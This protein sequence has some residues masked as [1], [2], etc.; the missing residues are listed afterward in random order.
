MKIAAYL[1][2]S[3]R[4]RSLAES[5]VAGFGRH[6]EEVV[7]YDTSKTTGPHP[8]DL[9]VFV[10]VRLTSQRV[11]K[12]ARAVGQK[13]MLLDKGYFKRG[14]YNRF[15]ICGFQPFYLGKGNTD[16]QR[17]LSLFDNQSPITYRPEFVLPF[18]VVYVEQTKK[19]YDFQDLGPIAEYSEKICSKVNAV[20]GN[21]PH[22]QLVYRPKACARKGKDYHGI[23][24]QPLNTMFSDP[25]REPFCDL[26][27]DTHCMLV[28][29]SNAAVEAAMARVPVVA[30]N[31]PA[32]PLSDMI[33]TSLEDVLN[34]T[35]PPLKK[36]VDRLSELA[37]CQ[38]TN[39]EIAS[40][41]AWDNLKQWVT[42]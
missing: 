42:A 2:Q 4:D 41:Y 11:N 23:P 40:G 30:I 25:D 35:M 17:L 29:G 22:L 3:I 19:Y 12:A 27:P 8:G 37:W 26:F 36:L 14:A 39:K 5:L 21:H 15:S 31:G 9:A 10:G 13:T 20:L 1:N 24:I 6:G 33:S 7:V 38:Y 32:C 28:D 18:K 34:P 16:P